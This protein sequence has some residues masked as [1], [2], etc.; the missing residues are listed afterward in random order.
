[1]IINYY[2][3]H[4]GD[5]AEAT[6]HLSF[7]EDAAYSRLMRKVYATELPLP[8][9]IKSVQRLVGARS[10]DERDAVAVVLE[11]FFV[12]SP[13]G[14]RNSRCDSE[15]AKYLASR[16]EADAK[17][18]NSRDRQKRAR[19][20]RKVL[21]EDLRSHGVV[22]P[23][24]ATTEQL[25]LMLSRVTCDVDTKPVTHHV[26][27]DNTANQTPDTRHHSSVPEGTGGEPPVKP[28][29][30]KSKSELWK[31][32]VSLLNGQGMPEPQAR[33]LI[34][35]LSKDYP[36]DDIVLKAVQGAV[37]EQPAD[38]RAY[39]KATC[40]RLNGERKRDGSTDWSVNAI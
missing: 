40:Q 20:R 34:G 23:W 24:D 17:K 21:F 3:H 33:S 8:A 28:S 35:K 29:V 15:I 10:K 32:A 22:A 2:E 25:Q 30:D 9:D 37:S 12:L 38:A 5:Y 31:A 27:R 14:W 19:E 6:A 16:P 13:E 18:E 26:T 7:I 36:T 1:M 11:E 39:L 4:L